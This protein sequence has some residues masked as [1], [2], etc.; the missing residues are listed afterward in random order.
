M[1]VIIDKFTA[2]LICI[3]L[4]LSVTTTASASGN[5]ADKHMEKCLAFL[6]AIGVITDTAEYILPDKS[7]TRAE[8]A[9][10]AAN[11]LSRNSYYGSIDAETISKFTD[12][13]EQSAEVINAVNMLSDMGIV[14]GYGDGRF[15]PD[16]AITNEQ[17]IKIL[18]Y[19]LGYDERA[20]KGGGYPAGYVKWAGTLGLGD[21]TAVMSENELTWRD[22][23]IVVYN[24]LFADIAQQVS[25]GTKSEYSIIEG[26]NLLTNVMQIKILKK[27]TV[28]ANSTLSMKGGE[29]V[30][31]G[32]VEIDGELFLENRSNASDYYGKL[33]N[34]YYSEPRNED[35]S[36]LYIEPYSSTNKLIINYEDIISVDGFNIYYYNESGKRKSITVSK[37]SEM[38]VNG[39]TTA[40]DSSKIDIN[41]SGEIIFDKNTGGG[42]EL[43]TVNQYKNILINH[44]D[45]ERQII[46]DKID[47]SYNIDLTELIDDNSCDIFYNGE[48]VNLEKL[49]AG[50]LLAIYMSEDS[51]YVRIEASD[52]KVT[53][54]VETVSDDEV[55]IAG[56]EY[57]LKGAAAVSAN[58]RLGKVYTAYVNTDNAIVYFSE[59]ADSERKYG[60]LISGAAEFKTITPKMQLKLLCEDGSVAV[61]SVAKKVRLGDNRE[62]KGIEEARA[63]ISNEGSF[64]QQLIRYELNSDGEID[65][66][67]IASNARDET[68]EDDFYLSHAKGAR[69]YTVSARTFELEFSI[70]SST[71]I[72]RVP[73]TDS[74][75]ETEYSVIK[76]S[77]LAS[78]V[79]Y[80]VCTYNENDSGVA[81]VMLVYHSINSAPSSTSTIV[82]VDS[83][84]YTTND[85]GV[86]V[87][88]L[89]ALSGGAFVSYKT[90]GNILLKTAEGRSLKRGDVV[91]LKLNNKSEICGLE[92]DVNID[93]QKTVPASFGKEITVG[94]GRSGFIYSTQNDG[95][96]VFALS[97]A[98][99]LSDIDLSATTM[100]SVWLQGNVMIYDEELD[101]IYAG[102]IADIQ[103]YKDAGENAT[104]F[105]AKFNNQILRDLFIFKFK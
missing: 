31:D 57:K 71:K 41:L 34:V 8:F 80:M 100:Y 54:K 13:N 62:K 50:M 12:M 76:M 1:K 93:T 85:E 27:V 99:K 9:V 40:Y 30:Q 94:W 43:V 45:Y 22:F 104:R 77:D 42:Y 63:Y 59:F 65:F 44:L 70:D 84:R 17:A 21:G 15:E 60:Y 4:L 98:E 33:V 10:A 56:N 105:F 19:M 89:K 74:D 55:T 87:Q 102:T 37:N 3:T 82:M 26:E 78:S 7:V 47:K 53:G 46:Y 14:S 79:K 95:Y 103:S 35:K 23:I 36:I 38:T 66:I 20:R 81:K 32:W 61:L 2:F 92:V 83:I 48:L 6:N 64:K 91:R 96:A 28:T 73:D 25:Y 52:R 49:T 69:T 16:T 51:E 67:Q 86:D 75:D 18:V 58:E 101:Q 68:K 5:E 24:A 39:R 88:M 72:F 97:A 90:D 11:I 29:G